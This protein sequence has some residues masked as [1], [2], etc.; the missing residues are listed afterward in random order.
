MFL[1]DDII[2]FF[3]HGCHKSKSC[4]NIVSLRMALL[5]VLQSSL[6]SR[7]QMFPHVMYSLYH[8][9]SVKNSHLQAE[10]LEHVKPLSYSQKFYTVADRQLCK[11]PHQTLLAHHHHNIHPSL[12]DRMHYTSQKKHSIEFLTNRSPSH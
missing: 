12:S 6:S 7:S 4:D 1:T 11:C 8:Q 9:N 3:Y 5:A 10:E 2:R